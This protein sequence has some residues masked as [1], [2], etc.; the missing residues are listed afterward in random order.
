MLEE[1]DHAEK[2]SIAELETGLGKGKSYD[3][4]AIDRNAFPSV[5]ALLF[6]LGPRSAYRPILYSQ[7]EIYCGPDCRDESD[8]DG[9]VRHI[10][11]PA[12]SYNASTLKS[13]KGWDE[14]DLV[15]VK[16]DATGRNFPANLA[17]FHCPKVLVVGNTQHLD[18]P[19][20]RLL[21]YAKQEKFDFVT[22]DH[23]RHHLHFFVEAGFPKVAWLPGLN[24]HPHPQPAA[25]QRT[26]HI[27]FVGQTGKFH[28]YRNYVLGAIKETGLPLH[29][30]SAPQNQAAALYAQSLVALN[31]SLNADLNLRV[32]EVLSSGGFLLTDRL[33][34]EAGLELLFKEGQAYEAWSDVGELIEKARYFLAHPQAA[35]AIAE[36][37]REAFWTKHHP[38]RKAVEFMKWVFEGILPANYAIERELRTVAV[39][40]GNSASVSMRAAI[41]EEVQELHLRKPNCRVLVGAEVDSRVVLDLLDLPRANLTVTG[42]KSEMSPDVLAQWAR[43]KAIRRV[44]WLGKNIDPGTADPWDVMVLGQVAD[45]P[46]VVA[47][48]L[49]HLVFEIAFAEPLD[50]ASRSRVAASLAG[51]GFFPKGAGNRFFQ[52]EQPS[53][54]GQVLVAKEERRKALLLLKAAVDR[55]PDEP[56]WLVDT[57]VMA[58]KLGQGELGELCLRTAIALRPT[59][60]QAR[61]LLAVLYRHFS[62]TQEATRLDEVLDIYPR[63]SSV[64]PEGA[65]LAAKRILVINNLYPPQELGGYGRLLADFTEILRKRGHEV[66]VLSSDTG[67]LGPKPDYEPGVDRSL[68][69]F[70]GWQGGVIQSGN[71]DE[72]TR[73]AVENIKAVAKNLRSFRPQLCLLGNIDF[74]GYPIIPTLLDARVPVLHHLGNEIP[75]YP[76]TDCPKSPLYRLATASVWLARKVMAAGFPLS[77]VDVIYPGALVEEYRCETLPARDVLRIAYASIVLPYKG[78]HILVGA[79]SELHRRNIPFS[80][81]IAGTTT[82]TKFVEGLKATVKNAGMADKVTFSGFLD[83]TGLKQLFKTHNV[84]AFPSQFD[85]PFGISQVEAMAAGMVVLSS[86]TGGASEVVENEQS[87]LVVPRGDPMALATTIA[88]L[89]QD[90]ERWRKIAEEG[91]RRAIKFFDIRRSVDQIEETFAQLLENVTH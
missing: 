7:N 16:A 6:M 86:G 30:V 69:L 53:L 17:A 70:G 36:R 51:I 2:S 40:V 54:M 55:F 52:C 42:T 73:C 3:L 41:Y 87:G 39:P 59:H 23:K 15:V 60:G 81:T 29:V 35:G 56:D 75:G 21:A 58:I 61:T 78:V 13:L 82:D 20:Q 48:V 38:H 76:V 27:L 50:S 44:K 33:A 45:G 43:A 89:L 24:V 57:A 18:A 62:R 4:Y 34:P 9:Q 80:C 10:R 25:K 47:K 84:L 49:E 90:A 91:Q 72:A 71:S 74:V 46:A 64:K 65:L 83:R 22:S 85:E 11:T 5:K 68:Q 79:L 14:P 1:V 28:P 26:P 67:Y 77:S 19:I 12:G 63:G 37:G 31:C 8:P 88:S 32:F 66:H